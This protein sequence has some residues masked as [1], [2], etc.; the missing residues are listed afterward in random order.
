MGYDFYRIYFLIIRYF[1]KFAFFLSGRPIRG[2]SRTA[3][4]CVVLRDARAHLAKSALP[5]VVDDETVTENATI[6]NGVADSMSPVAGRKPQQATGPSQQQHCH[7]E[8]P[9]YTFTLPNIYSLQADF[10]QFLERD[11]IEKTTL[12]GLEKS[13]KLRSY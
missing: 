9:S 7:V 4:N 10:R 8:T 6:T 1:G 12:N 11:L 3:E 13:G 5:N 2:M